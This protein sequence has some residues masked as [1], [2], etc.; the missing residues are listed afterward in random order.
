[1]GCG[2]ARLLQEL[3]VHTEGATHGSGQCLHPWTMGA[4]DR[5]QKSHMLR[6]VLEKDCSDS[7][8]GNGLIR[9]KLLIS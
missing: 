1:M 7:Y 6:P 4:T 3:W 5:F 8:V 2:G 9:I